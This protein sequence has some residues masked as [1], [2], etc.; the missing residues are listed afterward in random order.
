M[1][2][3][4]CSNKI[5]ANN[6]FPFSIETKVSLVPGLEEALEILVNAVKQLVRIYCQAFHT[7]FH[8]G[9]KIDQPWGEFVFLLTFY[10]F[11]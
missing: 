5:K 6:Y 2:N 1:R 3:L 9:N 8:L 4:S 10:Y 11:S 7:D